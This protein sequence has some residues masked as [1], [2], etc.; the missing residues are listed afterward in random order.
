MRKQLLLTAVLVVSAFFAKAQ[1]DLTI[2]YDA[3]QGVSGLGTATKVYMHSGGND[4][5][6]PLDGSS[7]N[8]VVG[9]WGQD[10]GIGQMTNQGGTIW[11]IT[12]D[13]VAYYSQASNGPV[14]GTSIARLGI[15]FRDEVG[16]NSGKDANNADIFMDL[17][18]TP[19]ETYNTDG[20]PFAGV[21][22][23]TSPSNVNNITNKNLGIYNAPNPMNASTVF[24]YNLNGAANVTLSVYDVTG[25][26]VNVLFNELQTAGIHYYN[27]IGDDSNGQLLPAGIYTYS[28]V[29]NGARTNGKLMIVR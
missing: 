25:R 14:A 12:I 7:W 3:S 27:W 29:S 2:T 22:G 5:P 23:T 18:T 21:V 9:N 28:L 11:A 24:A 15:V 6:G 1:Y 19:P 26:E 8:Y 4:V 20:T 13:P 17:T 16:V 10:D